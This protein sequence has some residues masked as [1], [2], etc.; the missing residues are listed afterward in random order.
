[1]VTHFKIIPLFFFFLVCLIY[2]FRVYQGQKRSK[3]ALPYYQK[4]LEYTETIK[5]ENSFECVPVLRELAGVEQALGFH[6]AAVNHFSRVRYH[7]LASHQRCARHKNHDSSEKA[8]PCCWLK[9]IKTLGQQSCLADV[10]LLESEAGECKGTGPC[11][12]LHVPRTAWDCF[13]HD[14][15]NQVVFPHEVS[16]SLLV[17]LKFMLLN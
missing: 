10:F 15:Y 8:W 14:M 5:D 12:R 17:P 9:T 13:S 4:A 1:M 6:D 11:C 3:E 7:P 16:L 2:F